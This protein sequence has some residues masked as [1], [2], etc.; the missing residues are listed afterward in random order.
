MMPLWQALTLLGLLL[1]LWRFYRIWLW[2]A[3]LRA[4]V[5]FKQ[6]TIIAMAHGTLMTIQASRDIPKK[7]KSRAINRT[8]DELDRA[9]EAAY[10]VGYLDKV[11][12]YVFLGPK[13]RRRVRS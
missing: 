13:L 6:S 1:A 10:R 7:E 11:G 5:A 2:L 8:K 3:R 9:L 12:L 4:I